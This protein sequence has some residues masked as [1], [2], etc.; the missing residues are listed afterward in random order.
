MVRRIRAEVGVTLRSFAVNTGG[1]ASVL[2]PEDH[3]RLMGISPAQSAAYDILADDGADM[4]K[5]APML[6]AAERDG[7]DPEAFARHCVKLR[8]AARGVSA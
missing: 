1:T 2:S 3:L 4:E 5:W 7:K 8:K 6:L